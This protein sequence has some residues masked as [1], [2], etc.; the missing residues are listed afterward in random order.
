MAEIVKQFGHTPE[1]HMYNQIFEIAESLSDPDTGIMYKGN[2]Y[3][4]I[5]N[6]IH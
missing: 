4:P 1:P 6:T 3:H 5:N 2:Y